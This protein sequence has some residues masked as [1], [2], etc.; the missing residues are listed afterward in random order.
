M[1]VIIATGG[2]DEMAID[3]SYSV[4]FAL[5]VV[6][7][8][9]LALAWW[10]RSLFAVGLAVFLVL[11]DGFLI[12]P[13]HFIVFYPLDTTYPYDRTWQFNMEVISIVWL[14]TVVLTLVGLVRA[15]TYRKIQRR[16]RPSA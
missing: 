14:L 9:M 2:L 11:L 16:Q 13:W 1:N 5:F 8:G 12:Q 3:I 7:A 15:L 10:K 4:F 6:I